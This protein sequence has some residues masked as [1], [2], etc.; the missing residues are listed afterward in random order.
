MENFFQRTE[1]IDSEAS[2]ESLSLQKWRMANVILNPDLSTRNGRRIQL[3]KLLTLLLIP[4]L[5]LTAQS[6]VNLFNAQKKNTWASN[7]YNS[8]LIL[9]DVSKVIEALQVERG[10]TSMYIES[11]DTDIFQKM[12]AHYLI[13]DHSINSVTEWPDT[14]DDFPF[15]N[16]LDFKTVLQDRRATVSRFGTR[17]TVRKEL[18]FYTMVIGNITDWIMSTIYDP[19]EATYDEDTTEWQN[20]IAVGYLLDIQDRIGIQRALGSVYFINGRL[21]E[22]NFQYFLENNA[23]S[24]F[25]MNKVRELDADLNSFYE[26]QWVLPGYEARLEN[27]TAEITERRSDLGS[28]RYKALVWFSNK[29]Y[30]IETLGSMRDMVLA[31][32]LEDLKLGFNNANDAMI[33]EIITLLVIVCIIPTLTFMFYKA[34]SGITNY[35]KELETQKKQL[36]KEKR[37][38]E[39]LLFQ[40]IPRIVAMRLKRRKNDK[41]IIAEKFGSVSVYFSNVVGFTDLS[42]SLPPRQV[43]NLLNTVYTFLDERIECYDVY[44]VETIN[45]V[46][47]VASGL[48]HRN[49]DR[50]TLEIALLALDVIYR[51]KR[52]AVSDLPGMEIQ[53]QVGMHTGPVV[54]GIVGNRMP[55]YC[56]FG[57]TVNTAARMQTSGEPQKIHISHAMHSALERTGKFITE[58]R[59]MT[60]IK[61]KGNMMTHWLIGKN[62]TPKSLTVVDVLPQYDG[63]I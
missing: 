19:D 57:D 27:M 42:S 30:Q 25:Y 28:Q 49:G 2:V 24:E 18:N 36:K 34:T 60:H 35:T 55:R 15:D 45:D 59:G 52:V 11:Y 43:V 32:H 63:P 62:R 38:T 5:A 48:P 29:T 4:L 21:N 39:Y 40:M 41:R 61:G 54:A 26:E 3:I 8:V 44:K 47:M 23:L 46:Y 37:K 20:D 10:L 33:R 16:V 31:D 56:L 7:E 12:Y 1:R 58:E 6:I 17:T 22:N 53:L 9:A 51:V 13:T 14:S 50:H